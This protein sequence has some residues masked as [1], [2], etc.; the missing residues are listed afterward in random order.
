MKSV[1]T[2]LV[3][4]CAFCSRSSVVM[5]L[6]CQPVSS[7]AR[8]TF[9]P[10]LPMASASWSSST[11]TSIEWRSS[12]TTMELTSAGASALI[13]NCAASGDQRM[14]STRSPASSWVTACTRE[15]RMPTHVPTGSMRWSFDLTAILARRPGSRA[16]ALISRRP[17]SISGTSSSK[18]HEEIGRHARQDQL[19]AA[20]GAVDL[21]DVRAD[22]VAHAEVFL[23]NQLVPREQRFHATGFDDEVAAL[24]A[25]HRAR[26]ERFAPLEE[27]VQDLLALG[28]ADLLQDHLLGG[29]GA[30]AA[31][32]F[33][34]ERLLDHVA[35]GGVGVLGHGIGDRDLVRRLLVLLVGHDGPA[36]EGRIVAGLAVDL[37]ADIDLVLEALLG[38]RG[39]RHLQRQEHRV[40]GDVLLA[41]QR[42]DQQQDFATHLRSF[43]TPAQRRSYVKP[44]APAGPGRCRRTRS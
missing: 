44:S 35:E 21:R 37:H 16:A 12:S 5:M 1:R 30:D 6:S 36:A 31:E 15:P 9:C 18:L 17:S 33:G 8:R 39:E 34:L 40:L 4:A 13:T 2:T 3:S 27:V 32:G 11:T 28:V 19:R 24:G 38:R 7:E 43:V 23:G 10:P 25:L 20:G 14:M 41:R 42:I 22:A 26:H 29:L